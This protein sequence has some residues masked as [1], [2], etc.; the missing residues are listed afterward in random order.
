[1]E[2]K[3]KKV[4]M[5]LPLLIVK[6]ARVKGILLIKFGDRVWVDLITSFIKLGK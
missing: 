6:K 1:M 3:I 4:T 5:Y 2:I